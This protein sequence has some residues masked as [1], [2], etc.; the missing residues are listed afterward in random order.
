MSIPTVGHSATVIGTYTRPADTTQYADGDVIDDQ[1]SAAQVVFTD[2]ARN[3]GGSGRITDA[4]LVLSANGT[5]LLPGVFELWLFDT[6][7]AAHEADNVA[8]TPTD[9]DM[10]NLIGLVRFS[11][12]FEA[13]MTAGAVG[14]VAYQ[15]VRSFL[16]V[17]FKCIALSANL[18]GT[19]VAGNAYTPV[20]GE[21]FTIRLN[22]EQD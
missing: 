18:H 14:N 22:V 6:A 9:G 5:A 3:A 4:L 8:F 17:G 19:L 7:V 21:V 2:V 11:T 16:P 1:N 20:S 13:D 15:A 10:L 12:P